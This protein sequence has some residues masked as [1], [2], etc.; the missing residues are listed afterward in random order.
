MDNSDPHPEPYDAPPSVI[1]TEQLNPAAE[2]VVGVEAAP[3]TVAEPD[4]VTTSAITANIP[5]PSDD[6]NLDDWLNELFDPFF[7]PEQSL[8]S[9]DLSPDEQN[10]ESSVSFFT[11]TVFAG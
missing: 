2:P 10:V 3:V 1:S 9:A 6:I 8:A 4:G 5:S 7:D 11:V